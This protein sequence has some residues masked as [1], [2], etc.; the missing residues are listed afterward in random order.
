MKKTRTS[1]YCS[2][3]SL[4]GT[5]DMSS[6]CVTQFAR[7]PSVAVWL[8]I[9]RGSTIMHGG[10]IAIPM[11]PTRPDRTQLQAGSPIGEALGRGGPWIIIERPRRR[12]VSRRPDP[13]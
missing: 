3:S 7:P 13:Q 12:R 2:S 5:S 10:K 4:S 11:H 9:I 8:E 6:C 1:S